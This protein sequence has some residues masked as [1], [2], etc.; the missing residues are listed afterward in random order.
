MKRTCQGEGQASFP[1]FFLFSFF[2]IWTL[3]AALFPSE[4]AGQKSDRDGLSRFDRLAEEA[5]RLNQ[6]AKYDE[7]ISL[8]EPHQAEKKNDSVLFFNELAV[9]YRNRDRLDNAIQAYQKALSL[10]PENPVVMKNLADAFYLKKEYSRTVEMAQK[11]IRSN[12]RFHQA[13]FTLGMAYYRLDRYREALD[14]F[15][16]VLRLNPQDEKARNS[17]EAVRKILQEKK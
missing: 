15:E 4:S 9:A 10:D 2:L 17:R 8:L 6:R 1:I 3:G 11:A 12:P 13:H 7:V 5:S 16:E 14:E